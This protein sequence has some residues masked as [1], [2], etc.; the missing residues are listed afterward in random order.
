M[1][2]FSLV[3]GMV[4]ASMQVWFTGFI[5]LEAEM[6]SEPPEVPEPLAYLTSPVGFLSVSKSGLAMIFHVGWL[7]IR[8]L[9][10]AAA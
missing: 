4:V 10:G 3:T 6:G 8:P 5:T 9:Y 2:F 7:S 1:L